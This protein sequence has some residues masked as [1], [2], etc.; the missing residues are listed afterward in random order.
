MK[1]LVSIPQ[2]RIL[3]PEKVKTH[4]DKR[5][6]KWVEPYVI[7][8]IRDGSG[9]PLSIRGHRF[10]HVKDE[11]SLSGEGILLHYADWAGMLEVFF[12]V[13]ESDE[14]V[15]GL[16]ETLTGVLGKDG[17]LS[18]LSPMLGSGIGGMV[19]SGVARSL[20]KNPDDVLL[21]HCM[22]IVEPTAAEHKVSNSRVAC[23]L[24]VQ[25]KGKASDRNAE[26]GPPSPPTYDPVSVS[27]T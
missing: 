13:I 3:P 24:R 18:K 21:A 14:D 6:E 9:E 5:R 27:L 1:V 12:S 17:P 26:D 11:V 19:L 20:A 7:A 15:R 23:V 2:L 22:S 25:F 10:D 8:T 16:G 4:G